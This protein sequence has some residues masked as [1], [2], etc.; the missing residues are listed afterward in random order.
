MAQV[1]PQE[2]GELL[3]RHAEALV[4]YASQWTDVPE[5]CVQ[6]TFV[7]LARQPARPESIVAWL[8]RVVRNR[9]LNAA[10]AAR[11][12]THHE[13]LAASGGER[14]PSAVYDLEDKETLSAALAA[15][16]TEDREIV[17][18]RVWSGLTWQQIADL[19]DT[20]SSSAQRCYVAALTKLRK[21]LEPPCEANFTY[22][23]N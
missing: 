15:L 21:Y 3:D 19:T 18:L 1:G 8:Y 23:P 2:I 12:R 4:L 17:V 10:R 16:T 6:E 7:E 11:R 13:Q 20:S 22:R 5:D 9:A 14:S